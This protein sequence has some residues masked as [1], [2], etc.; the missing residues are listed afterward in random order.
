MVYDRINKKQPYKLSIL[1]PTLPSRIP[2]LNRIISDLQEQINI[3]PVQILY[4]GDNKSLTVGEKR[5]L[6][7]DM[8]K[9]DY[10]CFIDD[11]DLVS[12]TYIDQILKAITE[13]P[14]VITF[15]LKKFVDDKRIR[16]AVYSVDAGKACYRA[17]HEGEQVDKMLPNHLC[18]WKKSVINQRF[19]NINLSEDHKWAE[20]MRGNHKELFLND[21][22]Y[23]YY[24]DKDVTECRNKR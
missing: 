15:K 21:Y 5:N 24:F 2:Y 19:P 3:K 22:L 17:I 16:D 6:L 11:D 9:G 12:D 14:D 18:I 7:M 8:S 4:L 10:L 23:L 13:N 1:I 20:K